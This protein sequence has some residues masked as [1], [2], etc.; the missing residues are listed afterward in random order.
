MFIYW[1]RYIRDEEHY[2]KVV[3]Y[4]EWNSVRAGL[5]EWP[6][7]WHF[8]SARFRDEYNQLRRPPKSARL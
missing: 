4:I 3:H 8:S 2:R 6:E 7:Q 1:D 5:V